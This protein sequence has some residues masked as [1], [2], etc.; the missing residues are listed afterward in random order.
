VMIVLLVI[1]L[2][3]VLSLPKGTE[4]D[5][6]NIKLELP[7]PGFNIQAYFRHDILQQVQ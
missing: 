6:V 7:V 2:C 5:N 4:E 3:T 1:N